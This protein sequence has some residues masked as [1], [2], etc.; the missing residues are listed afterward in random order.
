MNQSLALAIASLLAVDTAQAQPSIAVDNVISGSTHVTAVVRILNSDAQSYRIIGFR[1]TFFVQGSATADA[2]S[3]TL[4][5]AAGQT[6]LV[7]LVGPGKEQ[8]VDSVRCWIAYAI[9]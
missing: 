2:G 8:Q 4:N 7:N 5:L 9:P 1:C 6:V 3:V